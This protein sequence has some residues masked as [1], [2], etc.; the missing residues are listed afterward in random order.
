MDAVF[1]NS[2]GELTSAGDNTISNK[3]Y[4]YVLIMLSS[5]TVAKNENENAITN[6]L[7]I[8]LNTR[9]PP[10]FPF[11]FH[12]Q[13]IENAKLGTSTDF[14]VFGT[15]PFARTTVLRCSNSDLTTGITSAPTGDLPHS[16][17]KFEAKRLNSTLGK[18]REKEYVIGEYRLGK[19]EKNSGAIERFKNGRH[20]NDVQYAGIIGYIQTDTPDYWHVKVNEWI[21]EEILTPSDK[22]LVWRKD[23]LLAKD[24]S[25]GRVSCYSSV[26]TRLAGGDVKLKHFWVLSAD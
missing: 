5:L 10:E 20:G 22:N 13:N 14:A 3:I 16:I 2:F 8:E 1:S 15:V 17:V 24:Y 26:S 7:C 6:R 9:R 25:D 21:E 4:R 12:H 19:R 23:D 18:R 11:Y